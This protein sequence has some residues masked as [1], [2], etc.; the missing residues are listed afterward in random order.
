M[1]SILINIG[2]LAGIF[3]FYYIDLFSWFATKNALFFSFG[4]VVIV[5]AVAW[6]ILGNPFT[7]DKKNDDK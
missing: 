4:L 2:I 3:L 1:K 5:F 7:G 6:K